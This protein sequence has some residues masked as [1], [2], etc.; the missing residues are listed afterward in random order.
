M[1]RIIQTRKIWL[2]LSLTLCLLS[3]LSLIFWGMKMGIDFSGGSLI[4]LEFQGNRPTSQSLTEKLSELNLDSLTVQP[5]GEQ[6]MIIRT[7]TL[8]EDR[9]QEVL[10]KISEL[11]PADQAEL[12]QAQ[13]EQLKSAF[14]LEGE[15]LDQAKIEISGSSSQE[16]LQQ[17]QLEQPQLR[18]FQELRFDSIG[19]II[20]KELQNKTLYAIV[21]VLILIILYITYAFR[22]VSKPVASWKYG[23]SAII[24]LAHDILIV[25]G[26]F[27]VL[28]HFF[29]LQADSLF[30]TALLTILGF[31]VHDTI[32][33]FD[34]IREN[35]HRRQ[36][37]TFEDLINLSINETIIRSI[38]TTLTVVF[39][40]LS[41]L[42]FGGS[43][44]RNFTLTLVVGF[45]IGT[46]SSIFIASPLLLYFYKLKKY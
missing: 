9:H 25:I 26:L 30:V 10:N 29:N 33:T 18:N 2:S 23:L 41:T 3:I 1:Y 21:L 4:Q 45:I 39:V 12:E 19:P 13:Q 42:L 46:Y 7:I 34:R 27:S 40:L 5:V 20:G 6:G 22:K 43:S 31:S 11:V 17:L 28:G 14:G 32:V 16:I 35:L 15:G 24:A 44:V 8:S 37:L 36:D 38:N